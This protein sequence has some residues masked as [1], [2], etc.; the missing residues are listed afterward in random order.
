MY[1]EGHRDYK[2][3]DQTEKDGA[4]AKNPQM[5]VVPNSTILILS[6]RRPA[7][8]MHP[9]FGIETEQINKLNSQAIT[10]RA[11]LAGTMANADENKSTQQANA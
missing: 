2:S 5:S 3:D 8:N 1:S 10:N 6:S 7:I 11:E 9:T 4:I